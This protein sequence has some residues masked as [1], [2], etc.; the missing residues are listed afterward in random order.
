MNDGVTELQGKT[1]RQE[2]LQPSKQQLNMDNLE[3][4]RDKMDIRKDH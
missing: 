4:T 3:Y 1:E 2:T